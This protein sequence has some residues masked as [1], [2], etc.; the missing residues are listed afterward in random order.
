MVSKE[1]CKDAINNFI[2][3]GDVKYTLTLLDYLC[4]VKEFS[5]EKKAEAIR[6]IGLTFGILSSILPDILE[7][8]ERHFGLIRITDKNNNLI[9]VY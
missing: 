1:E 8:L 5:E 4:Q 2:K 7:E 9:L 6:T 3:T